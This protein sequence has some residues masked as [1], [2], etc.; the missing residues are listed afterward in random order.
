[1]G[2]N[3]KKQRP[4]A[5]GNKVVVSDK[6]KTVR[7]FIKDEYNP[8]F[9]QIYTEILNVGSNI[10]KKH[11]INRPPD[12]MQSNMISMHSDGGPSTIAGAVQRINREIRRELED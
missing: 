9:I 4:H 10:L 12:E 1:M 5:Q 2:L 11:G 6:L 8:E 7:A 3:L